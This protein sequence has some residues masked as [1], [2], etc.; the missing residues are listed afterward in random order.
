MK[1]CV[2][3]VQVAKG[4]SG[5]AVVAFVAEKDSL[6]ESFAAREGAL[7]RLQMKVSVTPDFVEFFKDCLD[8][9]ENSFEKTKAPLEVHLA[10]SKAQP[11]TA[12]TKMTVRSDG[13]REK[14][15]RLFSEQGVSS[16]ELQKHS[17]SFGRCKK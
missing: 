17:S 14:E 13:L 2:E 15:D 16:V 7:E 8:D 11:D 5:G 1:D 12:L 9:Q 6:N 3:E 10:G 4:P